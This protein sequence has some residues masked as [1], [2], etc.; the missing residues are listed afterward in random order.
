MDLVVTAMHLG[1]GVDLCEISRMENVRD[2]FFERFFTEEERLYAD[3]RGAGR[4][5]SYAAMFAAKEAFAK[6]L[7]TGFRGFGPEDVE[8]LRDS[9]GRPSYRLHGRAAALAKEAGMTQL[10]LSLTHEAGL[11]A[12]FCVARGDEA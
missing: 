8:I 4:A 11:A 6:A 10:Y 2:P 1:I 3:A 7:G 9:L 12:A 5:A